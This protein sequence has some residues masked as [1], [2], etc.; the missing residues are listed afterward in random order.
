MYIA[1][2]NPKDIISR[3][4]KDGKIRYEETLKT[5][6]PP[7]I[8]CPDDVWSFEIPETEPNF[9]TQNQVTA[10]VNKCYLG[11]DLD[12]SIVCIPN[13]DPGF[14]WLFSSQIAGLITAW[15]GAN[16]H[17]AIRAGELGIPAVI[18]SGEIL[19]SRWSNAK[20]LSIDCASKKVDILE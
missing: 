20:R 19:Y 1:A 10:K 3:A 12:G 6:L 8:T 4:I 5:S 13:A 15:G 11:E 2:N 17:M 14:D 16:S 18:G 9:I 7:L